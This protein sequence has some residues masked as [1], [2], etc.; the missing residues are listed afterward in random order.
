MGTPHQGTPLAKEYEWLGMFVRGN[1]VW[2]T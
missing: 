2:V 1:K